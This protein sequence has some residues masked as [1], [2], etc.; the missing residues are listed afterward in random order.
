MKRIDMKNILLLFVLLL[1][2]A[3]QAQ[4]KPAEEIKTIKIEGQSPTEVIEYLLK[5]KKEYFWYYENL[6][7]DFSNFATN[8][9][10]YGGESESMTFDMEDNLLENFNYGITNVPNMTPEIIK[11]TSAFSA[12][13][14]STLGFWNMPVSCPFSAMFTASNVKT[15]QTKP[16]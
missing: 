2:F 1:G 7:S 4:E 14:M 9:V 8:I 13:I 6:I 12:I 3:A 11:I 10:Y 15:P 5:G 16:I